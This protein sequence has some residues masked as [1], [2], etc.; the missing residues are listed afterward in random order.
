MRDWSLNKGIG[1]L[2]GRMH[3]KFAIGLG[4]RPKKKAFKGVG[5][6]GCMLVGRLVVSFASGSLVGRF[7]GSVG[8]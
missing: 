8:R 1:K 2:M 3:V 6:G 5:N 4:R 7:Q